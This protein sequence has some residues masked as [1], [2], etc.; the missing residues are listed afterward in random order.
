M[1]VSCNMEFMSGYY[2]NSKLTPLQFLDC[3][4][5]NTT[6]LTKLGIRL[7]KKNSAISSNLYA[8]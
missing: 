4:D 5:R 7:H 1:I 8:Q 6:D 2:S 3:M